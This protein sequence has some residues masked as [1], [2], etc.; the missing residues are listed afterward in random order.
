MAVEAT[1][2]L[3]TFFDPE[4]FAE[5]VTYDGAPDIAMIFDAAFFE[6]RLGTIGVE[7]SRPAALAQSANV[8]GVVNGKVI[9]RGATTYHVVGV[10]PDGTGLTLL[11]LEKQ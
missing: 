4:E 6:D 2:E 9:V 7:S 11:L 1:S 3:A 5:L 10:H 8:N